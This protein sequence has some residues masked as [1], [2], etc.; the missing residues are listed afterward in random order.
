[1]DRIRLSSSEETIS[2]GKSYGSIL[3]RGTTIALLGDLGTGKTTFVQGLGLALDIE[4]AIQS[5]TFNYLNIYQGTFPLYHFDL[6][7]LDSERNLDTVGYEEY[8][9]SRG[10]SVV[11]W[12]DR[13]KNILPEKHI[14]VKLKHLGEN[15]REIIIKK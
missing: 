14:E 2:F 1:M 10:I 15:K 7:R 5:P 8:F 11:E 4:D 12:A 3:S 6:Y 9:Y 13:A